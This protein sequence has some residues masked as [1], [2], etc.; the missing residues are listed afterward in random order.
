MTVSDHQERTIWVYG[1]V[2][3]PVGGVAI[4]LQRLIESKRVPLAGL[5]D[6]YFGAQKAE[7]P[8]PHWYPK[9]KGPLHRILTVIKSFRLRNEL[10]F[11]NGSRPESILALF[12]FLLFRNAKKSLLLHHGDLWGS[13]E[14]SRIK[15]ALVKY[16]LRGYN[17][18]FCLSEKQ[19]QFYISNDIEESRL[20]LVNSYIGIPDAEPVSE[21]IDGLTKRDAV[22]FSKQARE[23]IAWVSQSKSKVIIGSGYAKPF[24]NHEWVLDFLQ[25]ESH[26]AFGDVR[27][28]LCCYGPETDHLQQLRERFSALPDARLCFGLSPLEFNAVLA[29]SDI[30]VRPTSVD[31]FGI[32]IHDAR[33]LGLQAIASDACE[34]PK[35]I[36]VHE[37]RNYNQFSE[38]LKKCIAT[39]DRMEPSGGS[40]AGDIAGR[41]TIVDAL[42]GFAHAQTFV[43]LT[44]ASEELSSS[45]GDSCDTRL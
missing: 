3:Q 24:Y 30:Y 13:I 41:M 38:L 1:T 6:P 9:K 5:I 16:M 42:E 37:N 29:R 4:F 18:I 36:W 39:S 20:T 34:R 43:D 14:N 45:L 17:P 8:I 44:R 23:A 40:E 28:I 2:P 26:A 10:L 11:I 7:L 35:D 33:A 21:E 27:Y 32:A 25:Q 12:P 31:S 15:T 19:W 22:H